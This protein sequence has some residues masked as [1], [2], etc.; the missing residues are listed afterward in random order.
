MTTASTGG[1]KKPVHYKDA[2]AIVVAAKLTTT[3]G[4]AVRYSLSPRQIQ[5]MTSR[6]ILPA[7]KLGR[8]CLRYDTAAC[9]A[10]MEC[11]AIRAAATGRKG[12]V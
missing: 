4:L 11:F 5:L 1:E 3:N 9:D 12:R 10:A 2:G 8:R 7:V 6:G